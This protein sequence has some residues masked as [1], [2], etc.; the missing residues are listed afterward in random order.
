MLPLWHAFPASSFSSQD[1]KKLPLS[2][3]MDTVEPQLIRPC[4]VRKKD[5][6]RFMMLPAML[7]VDPAS[8]MALYFRRALM[9]LR[10]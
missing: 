5:E 3:A 10:P 9:V 2:S 8:E 7:L 1:G 4:K 6:E